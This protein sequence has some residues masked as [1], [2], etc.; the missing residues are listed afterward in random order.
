MLISLIEEAKKELIARPYDYYHDVGHHYKVWENCIQ[1]VSAEKISGIDFE[2][3]QLAAWVHDIDRDNEEKQFFQ[4]LVKKY[5]LDSEI[6]NKIQKLVVEHSFGK[7]QTSIE[8]RVLYDADKIEMISVPRWKYAFQACDD[9]L[10]TQEERDKYISEANRRI[11]LLSG[12]LHFNYS[13]NLFEKNKKE[14]LG[15]FRSLGRLEN[16]KIF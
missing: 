6:V 10:I 7:E 2:S 16:E 1:I 5:N 15:W 11:P 4:S 3:L 14:F 9:G 8:S 13:N 12:K